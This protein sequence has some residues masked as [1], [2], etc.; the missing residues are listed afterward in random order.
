MYALT[1][2]AVFALIGAFLGGFSLVTVAAF[3]IIL[4]GFNAKV[5]GF[6]TR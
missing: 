1:E 4:E 6:R 2:S 3:F 5:R